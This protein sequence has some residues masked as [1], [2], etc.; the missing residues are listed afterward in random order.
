M[1]KTQ[2]FHC[3]GTDSV[4]SLG[5]KILHPMGLSQ[6]KKKQTCFTAQWAGQRGGSGG[7]GGGWAGTQSNHYSSKMAT[8]QHFPTPFSGML[9][10][11]MLI[12]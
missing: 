4:P 11:L 8:F 3:R 1:V 10:S 12:S 5:T 6:R 2:R 9:S 7:Q